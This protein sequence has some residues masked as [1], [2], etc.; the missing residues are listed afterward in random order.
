MLQRQFD[1]IIRPF[2][3]IQVGNLLKENLF[4]IPANQR[5]YFWK[6]DRLRELWEDILEI[7]QERSKGSEDV[8]EIYHFL[9]PMFFIP[10]SEKLKIL[11]GQQRITTLT[12]FFRVI[13]DLLDEIR[14]EGR[15]SSRSTETYGEI[16]ERLFLKKDGK[17]TR[18]VELG[19]R[20][21]SVYRVLLESTD[22]PLDKLT[23]TSGKE[24]TKTENRL[25]NCYRFFLNSIY[26]YLYKKIYEKNPTDKIDKEGLKSLLNTSNTQEILIS[27]FENI[28]QGLYVLHVSVPSE[29]IAYKMFET[30]NQRGEKLLV[31][32]LFKNFLFDKFKGV[33][34]EKKIKDFWKSLIETA[35]EEEKLKFFVRHFW[36]SNYKFVR[37]KNLFSS[38]K[39][40]IDLLRTEDD[41]RDFSVQVLDEAKIY[42]ALRNHKDLMWVNK[43]RI[44]SIIEELN[45]LGLTQHLPLLLS[46]TVL[47]EANKITLSQL[48]EL[49]ESYLFFA[50]K[51]F[52]FLG[53]SPSEF[54]EEHSKLAKN[55]R[56]NKVDIT[57]VVFRLREI[58]PSSESVHLKIIGLELKTKHSRYFLSKLN[59]S[60][61]SELQKSWKNNPTV[62]HIIPKRP[63]EQWKIKLEEKNIDHKKV[64]N[65]L[66]NL[67]ILGVSEN[68]ELGNINYSQK[69]QKYLESGLPINL[70]TFKELNDF[71]EDEIKIR[72]EKMLE[73]I[74]E[75]NLWGL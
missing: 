44:A 64:I 25:V 22:H 40:E 19:E 6:E 62:E 61:C 74:K 4:F 65:R 68:Q 48:E 70:K 58:S 54:E 31:I 37:E 69:K 20:N 11:D 39:Q 2:K 26:G 60:F 12:I 16:K 23:R 53:E 56:E 67:T 8:Y 71:G 28:N 36:L 57:H 32:D 72:E 45:Y 10:S 73:M 24:F 47:M 41:F 66:G 50:V 33:V 49:A 21:D 75:K 35:D 55:L 42:F 30:L 51:K 7:M 1:E 17:I 9:G 27:F 18:R 43:P 3:P 5:V 63:E 14:E 15:L 38:I 52:M 46:A 59:D 13:Y 34:E 29:D